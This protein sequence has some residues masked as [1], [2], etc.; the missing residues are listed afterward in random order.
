[1]RRL[2]EEFGKIKGKLSEEGP[3]SVLARWL[4]SK[5]QQAERGSTLHSMRSA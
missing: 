2:R 4:L 3:G 5:Q 1:M